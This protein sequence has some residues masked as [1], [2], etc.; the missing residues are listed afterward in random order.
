MPFGFERST[1]EEKMVLKLPKAPETGKFTTLDPV[2]PFCGST[3]VNR[4][5]NA[6]EETIPKNGVAPVGSGPKSVVDATL[7][8]HAAPRTS[9]ASNPLFIFDRNMVSLR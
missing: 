9:D 2:P 3:N 5:T 7:G 1:R 4:S 8:E 6:L